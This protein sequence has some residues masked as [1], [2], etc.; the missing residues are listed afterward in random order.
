MAVLDRRIKK[1]GRCALPFLIYHLNRMK[2]NDFSDTKLWI[3]YHD[4][5]PEMEGLA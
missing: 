3:S 1:S 4:R 2:W 5:N